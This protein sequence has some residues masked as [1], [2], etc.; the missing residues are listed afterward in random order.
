[1]VDAMHLVIK[2]RL[3]EKQRIAL[4]AELAGMPMEEIG[5]HTGSNRNAVYKLTHDARKRLR[6]ELESNGFCEADFL[7]LQESN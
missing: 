4:L 3:T 2:E 7:S 1:M 5:R 6:M